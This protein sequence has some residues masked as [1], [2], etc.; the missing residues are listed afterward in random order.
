MSN[1]N[2]DKPRRGRPPRTP[3]DSET[4]KRLI[5]TG[6]IFLTERGYSSAGINEII[7]QAGVPKGVFYHYFKSKEVYGDQLIEA[8]QG[9]FSNLL[10]THFQNEEL[11]PLERLQSFVDDATAG[12]ARHHFNRG[13]LVGNLGQEMG[14]LPEAFRAKLVSI[15]LDWQARTETCLRLA[16]KKGELGQHHDPRELAELFWIGWEG[17][18]L[19]AKLEQ[20][21][22]PLSIFAKGFFSILE[23]GRKP[24]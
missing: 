21:P 19:R 18:V 11:S 5:R 7:S 14:T 22:T 15:F 24:E 12:M 10:E 4:R 1:L 23:K 17:A 8:Y 9:Y 16:Q 2:S 3:D 13:C 20:R 6:L